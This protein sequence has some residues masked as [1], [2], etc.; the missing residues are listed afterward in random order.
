ME[1]KIKS[2]LDVGCAYGVLV[3]LCNKAGIDTFG[4]DLPIDSLIAYHDHLPFSKGKFIY[5]SANDDIFK[6]AYINNSQGLILLDTLR[7]I[8]NP[9]NLLHYH[10]EFV[11]IKEVC[12]NYYIR[13]QRKTFTAD[14]KIYTPLDCCRLFYNYDA[15]IIFPSKYLFKIKRPSIFSLKII[16]A[17][18]PTYTLILKKKLFQ[19]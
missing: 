9:N 10:F 12:N 13:K 18:F 16:N 6:T 4:Y 11:V 8:I 15:H 1:L 3:D 17:F 7:H 14:Y 19:N 5:G 2:A